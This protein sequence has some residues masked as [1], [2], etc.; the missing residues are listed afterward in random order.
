MSQVFNVRFSAA[1]V[2]DLVCVCVVCMFLLLFDDDDGS[3]CKLGRNNFIKKVV[4]QTCVA[5]LEGEPF[6]RCN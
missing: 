3:S 4:L 1:A 6:S 5:L 2:V